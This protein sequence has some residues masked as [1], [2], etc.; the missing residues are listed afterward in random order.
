MQQVN[1]SDV[2]TVPKISGFS[3][4]SFFGKPTL[5]VILLAYFIFYCIVSG[6]LFYHWRSYGMGS[7]KVLFAETVFLLF[8]IVLF[9]FAG[10]S[11][12]YY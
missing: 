12:T 6:V 2:F 8:S 7:K 10:V 1:L 11:I 5:A 4:T 9:V 3:L